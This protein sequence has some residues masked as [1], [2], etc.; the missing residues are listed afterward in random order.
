MT[1]SVV[2]IHG[3]FMNP[4]SWEGWVHYFD[5]QGYQCYTPAY[6]FHQGDPVA[7][8]QEIN[9]KLGS[10]SLDTVT[11]SLSTFI[12]TLPGKP[13][14]IGH[15]MG[16]LIVQKLI[17]M[18]KGAAGICIDSAPPKGIISF[19]LSFLKANFPII[20]PLKGNSVFL[21]TLDWFHYAFCNGMTL[22]ET[23]VAFEN[24]AVP[25]SR[26]IARSSIGKD[27]KIDFKKPHNPLLFIAGEKD[28]LV[29][30][31]LNKKNYQAYRDVGSQKQFKQ[32]SGRTHFICGQLGW[33]EVAA[34]SNEW[35][36]GLK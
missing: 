21:P 26:N 12:D 27:G 14:L 16:G 2:F 32:F 3:L 18:D 7:L 4:K 1:K 15:S 6:P 13:I 35:I 10:L 23:K 33:E 9:Q 28:H 30:P 34:Y 31:S 11:K 25:E 19:D 22:D 5:Q 17:E 29:P 8:R 20:N 24:Y 36:N